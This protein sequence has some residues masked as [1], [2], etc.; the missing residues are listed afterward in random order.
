[1]TPPDANAPHL[2]GH[3][4]AAAQVAD[5]YRSGRMHHAWMLCGIEGIGKAT[6]TRHIA[7]FILSNGEGVIGKAAMHR[8]ARL[9]AAESHPDMLVIRRSIDEK[10]GNI[11]GGILLEDAQKLSAFLHM[12]ATLGGWRVAVIEDAHLLNRNG[13]NAI[14]KILEEPP[15]RVLILM[16]VTTPGALLPTIRSRCRVLSLAPL[17]EGQMRAILARAQ[18]DL[19]NTDITRLIALS[20]GSIGFAL[21]LVRTGILPLYDEALSLLDAMPA[22]DIPRLHKL[23]DQVGRKSEAESFETLTALL[24]EHM[25]ASIRAAA[26]AGGR[27]ADLNRQIQLWDKVRGIFATADHANLDHKLA[28][29]NA[30]SDIR[31][32]MA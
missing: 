31:A 28:F 30:I 23:A 16:T 7:Q 20:G 26:V 5:A 25:R 13:Q 1:M 11:R 18:P 9:V 21:K 32:A 29:I 6:L 8:A 2:I 14:L 3:D 10:T 19:Q 4:D 12:T 22:L 24:L 27:A 17:D 15:P